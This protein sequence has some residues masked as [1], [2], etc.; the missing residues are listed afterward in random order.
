MPTI[1]RATG[2]DEAARSLGASEVCDEQGR[3]AKWV[4]PGG[5]KKNGEV[6][7]GTSSRAPSPR[8][9]VNSVF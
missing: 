5:T 9:S 3:A 7:V 6:K 1:P 8:R 4:T 2:R